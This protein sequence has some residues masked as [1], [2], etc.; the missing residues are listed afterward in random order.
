[1]KLID[2]VWEKRNLNVIT[3]EIEFEIDE[4]IQ[5]SS[6]LDIIDNKI[7]ELQAKYVVV[8][9][10]SGRNDILQIMQ[11]QGFEFIESQIVLNY[12]MKDIIQSSLIKF[13]KLSKGLF[14]EKVTFIDKIEE[15]VNEVKKG[16]FDTDRISKDNKFGSAIANDRYS[17]WILDEFNRGSNIYITKKFNENIG[18]FIEK[19]NENISYGVLGGLYKNYKNSGL[20]YY[21]FISILIHLINEDVK[22]LKC[23]VSSNNL[24]IIKLHQYLGAKISNID[25]VMVKHID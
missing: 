13:E 23:P 17:N 11:K 20:G 3:L 19:R 16:I 18:F 25:Y 8:K 14:C 5:E 9:I 6:A 15:I 7:R 21:W 24:D 4:F 1:M 22:V 10:P 12:K 2:A